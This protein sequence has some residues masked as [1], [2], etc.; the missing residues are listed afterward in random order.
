[1][2]GQTPQRTPLFWLGYLAPSH[3]PGQCCLY[4]K[5]PGVC[6]AGQG[7]MLTLEDAAVLA[8]HLQQGGLNAE[9]M[10]RSVCLAEPASAVPAVCLCNQ[11]CWTKR[12]RVLFYVCL[13]ALD[14]DAPTA[15]AAGMRQSAP[16]ASRMLS[17]MAMMAQP[18]K[19]TRDCTML[20]NLTA[21]SYSR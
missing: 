19:T 7:M 2:R 21:F 10:R 17:R 4:G 18:M 16:H 13:P 3:S 15:L 6:D 12:F 11:N 5:P 20:S 8:W 14:A 1:M 9:S